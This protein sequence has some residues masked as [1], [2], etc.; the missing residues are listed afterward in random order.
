MRWSPHLPFSPPRHQ[1]LHLRHPSRRP[2][3]TPNR[4]CLAHHHRH[5]RLLRTDCKT[6][7]SV[8]SIGSSMILRRH[9]F[10]L[11]RRRRGEGLEAPRNGGV[12]LILA[13]VF[14]KAI[15]RMTYFGFRSVNARS[16]SKDMTEGGRANS[17]R[18]IIWIENQLTNN[19]ANQGVS[20]LIQVF[21][22]SR[23]PANHPINEPT[24]QPS[25]PLSHPPNQTTLN[26]SRNNQIIPKPT[27]QSNN[28][29]TNHLNG[30]QNH[31]PTDQPNSSHHTKPIKI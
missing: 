31:R 30:R 20:Q 16:G 19:L 2:R 29:S 13:V 27:K 3:P 15:F 12:A 9:V 21:S 23:P 14:P 7:R 8:Q 5:H 26:K 1:C 10:L 24:S 28:Q 6:G 4:L 11:L 18:S 17:I 25:Q 22:E